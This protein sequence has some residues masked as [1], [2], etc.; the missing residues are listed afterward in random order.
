MVVASD[1][2]CFKVV[3][4]TMVTVRVYVYWSVGG[5]SQPLLSCWGCQT[6]EPGEIQQKSTCQQLW[7]SICKGILCY[8]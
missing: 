4:T 5:Y 1:L 8:V 6:C 7:V 2:H 3:E